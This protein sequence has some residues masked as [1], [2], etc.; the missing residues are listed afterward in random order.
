MVERIKLRKKAKP[1]KSVDQQFRDFF[2]NCFLPHDGREVKMV[3]EDGGY[4]MVYV[5][6]QK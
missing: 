5:E 2:Y 3:V 1:I 6:D 4:K